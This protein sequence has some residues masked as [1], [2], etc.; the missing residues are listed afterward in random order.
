MAKRR[1]S[2][3]LRPEDHCLLDLIRDVHGVSKSGSVRAGI[4]LLAVKLGLKA[5]LN[6]DSAEGMS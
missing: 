5:P 2:F 6:N 1:S 3:H 4:A